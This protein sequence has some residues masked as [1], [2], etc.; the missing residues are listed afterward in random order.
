[1]TNGLAHGDLNLTDRKRTRHMP[2]T[3]PAALA[4]ETL[5]PQRQWFGGVSLLLPVA[6]AAL[7]ILP[8]ARRRTE[9]PITLD[10]HTIT[11]IIVDLERH[12]PGVTTHLLRVS[13]IVQGMIAT[14]DTIEDPAGDAI[15][16]AAL[17]HD[18]GKIGIPAKTLN[19]PGRLDAD[20]MRV[21]RQHAEIG[22]RLIDQVEGF[23]S[24]APIVRHHHERW[25][26]AGYPDGLAGDGI[27]IGARLIAVADSYDAMTSDR[28]YRSALPR[29]TA[30][31]E[32]KAMSGTQ[33]DPQIVGIFCGLADRSGPGTD[34]RFGAGHGPAIAS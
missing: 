32:L 28:S 14:L 29:D 3:P 23:A 22:Q 33:F 26:G 13:T 11:D 20:E 21:V 27:P 1:M 31:A 4:A 24:A 2:A 6:A 25:D 16:L 18:I 7:L 10:D 8:T 19:K 34:D 5:R 12:D 30:L 9:G 17:V 15:M